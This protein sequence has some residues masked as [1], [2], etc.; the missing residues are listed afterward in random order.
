MQDSQ[1]ILPLAINTDAAFSSLSE[2]ESPFIKDL[3]TDLNRNP[4]VG[5]GM[6][7]PTEEGQSITV[8]T[9]SKANVAIPDVILPSGYNKNVGSFESRTTQEWYCMNFNG[10]RNHG[11]YVFSGNTGLWQKVIIDPELLFSDDPKAYMSEHRC[12]LRVRT[13]ENNNVIEKYLLITEGT[14]YHKW[15]DVIAAIK[16]DGFNAQLYPYFNLQPPHFDRQEL[17]AWAV[18]SPMAAP[19]V[20]PLPNT[21]AQKGTPNKILGAAFQVCYQ[22]IFT[23]GRQTLSSPFSLPAI[24]KQPPFLTNQNLIPKRLQILMDAG[25]CKTEKRNIF[26][27]K[28]LKKANSDIGNSWGDWY[29][30]DTIYKFTDSGGNSPQVIGNDYWKRTGA[31]GDYSYNPVKN[32]IQYIFDNTKLGLITDQTLFQRL[33]NEMPQLSISSSDLGDAVQ[34]ANN[35]W[36]F[37]NFPDTVINKLS[38]S[39]IETSVNSCSR[40]LR[41]MKL[42]VYAGRERGDFRVSPSPLGFEV[43]GSYDSHGVWLSQVGFVSGTDTTVR[44]GGTYYA[45]SGN[46]TTPLSVQINTE[47]SKFFNLDF[48]DKKG[49]RCYLKGT[50]YFA[51]CE[52]YTSDFFYNLQPISGSIN[53]DNISDMAFLTNTVK[54]LGFFVGVFTFRVPAGRYIATLGRHNVASDGEYR[55]TSTYIM[56][57]ANSRLAS[58]T[59]YNTNVLEDIAVNTVKPNA[60][61]SRYKE[62]ELDCTSGDVDLWGRGAKGDMFYVCTPFN[63]YGNNGGVLQSNNNNW[64]FIEGYL[65]ESQ[66]SKIPMERFLYFVGT[67]DGYVGYTESGLFTDKNGFYF[68]Y[69][70][71]RDDKNTKVDINFLNRVDCAPNFPFSIDVPDGAGWFNDVIAYFDNY[72]SGVVGDGNYVLIEGEVKNL[73]NTLSYSNIAVSLFGGATS[74][75]RDDGTFTIVSHN[76]FVQGLS[77]NIY[78]NSSGDFNITAANCGYPPLFN[79]E[80][81]VCQTLQTRRVLLGVIN[82]DSQTD[83]LYSLKSG[84][85]YLVGVV[86]ADIASRVTYVNKFSLQDISSF[87][88]RNNT[89]ATQLKWLLNSSLDLQNDISTKD[90]K[91][92]AFF[93]INATKY[94]KYIQW[95]GDSIDFIDTNGN[96]TN[97]TNTASLVRIDI[98]SL[99]QT[100]IQNNFT[101]IANYQFQPEDRLRVID[102]GSGNILNTITYGEEINV[103]VQGTS[104]NEAAIRANLIPP[105]ENTVI[106]QNQITGNNPVYV[107]VKYDNR[108]DVLKNKS[109]FWIELYTPSQ[110]TELFPLSQVESFYPVINGTIA[111]YVSGGPNTPVYN[112]PSEGLLNY[113][114][115]YLIRRNIFG[116]GQYI[117]HPF[118][119]PN[120][121]DTWG[122][123]ISSGGKV[124]TIN[125]DSEMIWYY[126]TTIKS[127]D[128]LTNGIV[129]GLSEFLFKDKVDFKGYQ[130]GGIV[131]IFC[132]FST[133]LFICE[134]DWF[135]TD[136]NFQY[137]YANA[138][139]VQVANL[140]DNLSVPHQKIGQNFGCRLEDTATALGFDNYVW[141]IDNKNQ[142]AIL[143]NYQTAIDVSDITDNDGKKYGIKSY[144]YKKL[145]AIE[146]WNDANGINKRFDIVCGVDEIRNKVYVTF[147]PRRNNSNNPLAYVNKRRDISLLHQET[148]IYDLE[149][150]RWVKWTGMTP[151]AYG[152]VRGNSTGLEFIALAAGKPY[153][154]NKPTNL[155][156]N[157]FGVQLEP[158]LILV[159]NKNEDAVKVLQ[160]ISIDM[161]NASMYSDLVYS[162]Q[163]YGYSYI[164]VN[165]FKEQEKMFYASFFRDMVTYLQGPEN[166]LFRSTLV[167][168]K[169]LFGQYFLVRLVQDYKTLGSFFEL[170]DISFLITSSVPIKPPV[171]A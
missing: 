163:R 18:R 159:P 78:I 157:F 141:W 49:F 1:K 145:N 4:D 5:Y 154:Q 169:R 31:W 83:E 67:S 79:Y 116:L 63:G 139:G 8:L 89:N 61:V 24:I 121:T 81:P 135:V 143:N 26:V 20:S 153:L 19:I 168:G 137:I 92:L 16:T 28:T 56:G 171:T 55:D 47:E 76:G 127:A 35:R 45:Y 97:N 48:A 113:W 93:V 119:S 65:Y 80:E 77:A 106:D 54:N 21:D 114:D 140:E 104:Y 136:Y 107:F 6:N 131:A 12:T 109:G 102:D 108:F 3:S 133:I 124:Q 125:A 34:L 122:A 72:N 64:R 66:A 95:V 164:P 15:I 112:F 50:P 128:Y 146:N 94:R 29:L 27:R 85:N 41:E 43:A 44:F 111:E 110:N 129:N 7:N 156:T 126:D 60:I 150:K 170:N 88:Q 10:E 148:V 152:R 160:S 33:G 96:V 155:F 25:S 147:R 149:K 38:T 36:G 13:D 123:N 75:T 70:W 118:E 11:I 98:S 30:Y 46:I 14:T 74:Y 130:R 105:S 101:L 142:S 158:S 151:E 167:D 100:N 42:Y 62:I 73:S 117:S 68:G 69:S 40:P 86:G 161:N 165:K 37:N 57:I 59:R 39:V 17:L 138:Q 103:E 166:N 134:N 32:T 132:Q 51:D 99:L 90:I 84:G 87:Q 144:L 53:T 120:I 52:W 58:I 2:T 22:D 9:P 71:L 82:I 115:T 91:W 23:D 162:T